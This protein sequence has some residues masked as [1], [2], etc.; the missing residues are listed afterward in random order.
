MYSLFQNSISITCS[1]I[2][3]S[4]DSPCHP[5]T[6]SSTLLL[7]Y[8]YCRIKQ[9]SLM[10]RQFLFLA[11]SL[12]PFFV[13]QIL[14]RRIGSYSQDFLKSPDFRLN[15]FNVRP[16]FLKPPV[17]C[18]KRNFI[19]LDDRVSINLDLRVFNFQKIFHLSILIRFQLQ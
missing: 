4:L 9:K 15:P 7:G 10:F 18:C 6:D 1:A 14:Y 17:L 19:Q 11:V 16:K 8:A 5:F 2:L 3:E 13:K 12:R